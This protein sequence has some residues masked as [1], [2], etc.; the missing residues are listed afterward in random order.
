MMAEGVISPR[1][2]GA[3]QGGPLSPLLSNILLTDLDREL[4]RRGHAFCRYADDCNIYVRSWQAGERLLASLTRFLTQRLK[5]KVNA[6]KSAVARPW[7][8]KFLGY[9]LT[10]H[11]APRR[12]IAPSSLQR[13]ERR[14]RAVVA[15]EVH[16]LQTDDDRVGLLELYQHLTQLEPGHAP[17][18]LGLADAQLA[19][20]DAQGAR[21]SLQLVEQDPDVG[22]EARVRLEQLSRSEAPAD[23]TGESAALNR[24]LGVPLQRHGDHFLVAAR[25]ADVPVKKLSA[26]QKRV[27]VIELRKR[28]GMVFQKPNPFPKSIY[29]N[30]AYGPKIHGLA[31]NKAEL[32][33]LVET[34]L[35]KA[36]LW[37]EVKDS[38]DHPGTGLSGGQQQRLCIARTIAVSPEV[39]LMDEPCSALDPIATA[40]IEDLIDELREQ[41]SIAIVTHSIIDIARR[42]LDSLFYRQENRQPK[43]QNENQCQNFQG[44]QR[45]THDLHPV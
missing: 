35:K 4:E 5:L 1:T 41:Y 16:A 8:R 45:V 25:L 3:P 40:V 14:I 22:S 27:D 23:D 17:Y 32:D 26:G 12:R 37:A 42:N 44:V 2:E 19:L 15:A 6:A 21:R 38:L 34:S 30:I 39:I 24:T 7:E 20:N 33:N 18:F 9:S 29:D 11:K 36:G 31:A 43:H 28:M 10:G 13:L